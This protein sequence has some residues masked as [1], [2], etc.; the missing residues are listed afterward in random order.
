VEYMYENENRYM[1]YEANPYRGNRYAI[2]ERN[3]GRP[4]TLLFYSHN[5]KSAKIAWE[6][7]KGM[8]VKRIKHDMIF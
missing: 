2:Y 3:D 7:I 8:P 6:R 1:K 4:D 5:E